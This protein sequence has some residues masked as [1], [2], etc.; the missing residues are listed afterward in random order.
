MVQNFAELIVVLHGNIFLNHWILASDN[1]YL[2]D[3]PIFAILGLIFGP[4]H[5]LTIAEPV[6]VFA[7][8]LLAAMMLV[9]RAA[10]PNTPLWPGAVAILLLL[11]IPFTPARQTFLIPA[12]H[13]A[14]IMYCLYAVLI[15]QPVLSGKH[16]N[17][18]LFIPFLLLLFSAIASDPL[19]DAFFALPLLALLLLRV[20]FYQTL[21]LDEGIIFGLTLLAC[22]SGAVWPHFTTF[23]QG[24][25]VN[26][27]YV[28]GVVPDMLHLISNLRGLFSLTLCW[29]DVSPAVLP[30]VYGAHVFAVTRLTLFVILFGAWTVIVWRMP[31]ARDD[32]LQ[33]FFTLGAICLALANV[34]SINFYSLDHKE[35]V[36]LPEIR[37]LAPGFVILVIA[38]V[39]ELQRFLPYLLKHL[40]WRRAAASIGI[41]CGLA[42][43]LC[44]AQQVAKASLQPPGYQMA[45]SYDLTQWLL[46]Q[47]YSYGIADYWN[48]NMITAASDGKVICDP[49]MG[50]APGIQYY[51]LNID[52]SRFQAKRRPQFVV[53]MKGNLSLVTMTGAVQAYGPPVKIDQLGSYT[54]FI[55]RSK[56]P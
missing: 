3:L 46:A 26:V 24:F 10:P 32:G 42:F 52:I 9:R 12:F 21:S 11:G 36:H 37:F 27:N 56:E 41:V 17:R 20:W 25:L 23:H 55:P 15:L 44:A 38:G 6:I 1:D 45:P 34:A 54:I 50:I 53:I 14:T 8:I 35:G 49:A 29:F 31:R 48:A 40:I 33:Q 30:P 19:T 28:P 51:P 2:T 18:L 13:T 5:W 22:Y 43:V 47:H 7:L 16:V 4:V 39:I